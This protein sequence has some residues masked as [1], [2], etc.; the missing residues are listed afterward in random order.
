MDLISLVAI[1]VVLGGILV[2]VKTGLNQVIAGLQ[3]IDEHLR[4]RTN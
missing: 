2:A 4:D 1:L 3:S